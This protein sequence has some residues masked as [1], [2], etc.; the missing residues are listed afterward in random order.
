MIHYD[1]SATNTKI[2]T[3]DTKV[4]FP[5]EQFNNIVSI[6]TFFYIARSYKLQFLQKI[7]ICRKLD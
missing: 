5:M 4:S 2:K 7:N 6:L 1:L 3:N